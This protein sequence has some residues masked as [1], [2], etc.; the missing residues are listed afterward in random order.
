MYSC[1]EL[2][3]AC[4][5][6]YSNVV[7]ALMSATKSRIAVWRCTYICIRALQAASAL[8]P[9][10]LSVSQDLVLQPLPLPQRNLYVHT[11][12]EVLQF[13]DLGSRH[14]AAGADAVETP[15]APCVPSI[16]FG[17]R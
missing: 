17:H 3:I 4:T 7:Y 12:R 6:M 8:K 2:P 11:C 13:S 1:W 5:Q 15:V 14:N 16:Q 9:Y 10:A